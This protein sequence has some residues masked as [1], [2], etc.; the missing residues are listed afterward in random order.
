MINKA[1]NTYEST[2]KFFSKNKVSFHN[3]L[4]IDLPSKMSSTKP[5]VAFVTGANGI[6]G[7]AIVEHLIRTPKAEWLVY[8]FLV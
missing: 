7:N 6:S 1:I 2:L 4:A 5:K 8:V 3:L